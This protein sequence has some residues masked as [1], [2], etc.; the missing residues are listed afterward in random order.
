MN[1]KMFGSAAP[2]RPGPGLLAWKG[3]GR[4]RR[5]RAALA[6]VRVDDGRLAGNAWLRPGRPSRIP[7]SGAIVIGRER[8]CEGREGQGRKEK[9]GGG[10]GGAE[11]DEDENEECR[12]SS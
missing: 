1:L 10:G 7:G 6:V 11:G 5:R 3:T 4:M 8:G 12:G 9:G 2:G